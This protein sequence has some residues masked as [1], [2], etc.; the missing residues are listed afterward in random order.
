MSLKEKWIEMKG[1]CNHPSYKKWNFFTS[2]LMGIWY[3]TFLPWLI[4]GG[5]SLEMF[6][7]SSAILIIAY[8]PFDTY[9]YRKAKKQYLKELEGGQ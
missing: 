4:F 9:Y 2:I 5:L 1:V 7:L 6:L 3:F 8:W